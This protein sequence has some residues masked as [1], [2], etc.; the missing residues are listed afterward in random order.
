MKLINKILFT[1]IACSLV[2]P[3]NGMNLQRVRDLLSIVSTKVAQSG[4]SKPASTFGACALGVAAAGLGWYLYNTFKTAQRTYYVGAERCIVPEGSDVEFSDNDKTSY[5]HK[6]SFFFSLKNQKVIVFAPVNGEKKSNILQIFHNSYEHNSGLRVII[7][8]NAEINQ[9]PT[10]TLA[11]EHLL[12][13]FPDARK[14]GRVDYILTFDA[15]K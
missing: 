5:A 10:I 4:Y 3:I 8:S 11:K 12:V 7:Y 9:A 13:K 1:L 6:R 15:K 2:Q 14:L